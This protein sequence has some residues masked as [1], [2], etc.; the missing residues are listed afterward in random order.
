MIDTKAIEEHIR[1]IL[2][3]LGDDPD[4]EGLRE[5][6]ERVAKMYEE[7]FAGMNYTN[8]EVADLFNKTFS[9]GFEATD[10][11][12][13]VVL[14]DI[15]LFSY[16]EHHMALMYDMKAT[17]AYIP[18]GKVIGLSKIAR[19]CDM[20]SRRLQLQERIGRD[21][22]DVLTMVTG[23]QDVAVLLEG[24]HSCM[25]AR[26]IKKPGSKTLSVEL[27]GKFKEDPSLQ[28]YLR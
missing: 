3:A 21:I 16:C 19:I 22:A 4:R 13:L 28:L 7:V 5:T 17:V 2:I 1:G 8:E 25:T 27:R 26:G 20:V 12:E 6:P 24:C 11:K 10:S 15:D 18:A 9:E 14:K 23:S